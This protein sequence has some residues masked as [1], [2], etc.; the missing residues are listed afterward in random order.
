MPHCF[1]IS[2]VSQAF[3]ITV[4]IHWRRARHVDKWGT[5]RTRGAAQIEMKA[6]RRGTA[7]ASHQ[8]VQPSRSGHLKTQPTLCN[9][10]R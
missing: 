10:V 9:S 6:D 1:Q 3:Y 8:A 5:A 7:V 4:V 2:R